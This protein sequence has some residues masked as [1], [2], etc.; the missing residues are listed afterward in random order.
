MG[1]L[2]GHFNYDDGTGNGI[3]LYDATGGAEA[4]IF[5]QWDSS[6]KFNMFRINKHV[7]I[8]TVTA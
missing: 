8:L 1:N 7:P 5:S 6:L 3:R 4:A 2:A